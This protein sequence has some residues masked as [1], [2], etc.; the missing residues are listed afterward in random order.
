MDKTVDHPKAAAERKTSHFRLLIADW[1][2]PVPGGPA[3]RLSI[4]NR[5]L[6]F[7]VLVILAFGVVWLGFNALQNA[8]ALFMARTVQLFAALGS[9]P[10]RFWASGQEIYFEISHGKRFQ[11]WLDTRPMFSNFPL[12]LTLIAVTPGLL[13]RR[14]LAYVVS[15]AALL[16]LTHFCFLYIKVQV[17]LITANHIDAGSPAVWQT[18][19]DLFEVTGKTFFPIF[20][21]LLV[22]FPY[23]LGAVD[24]WKPREVSAQPRNAPC[25]CGSGLKYKKCCGR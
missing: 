13:W 22:A 24:T 3:S 18:L 15:G 7:V 5:L 16:L 6:F 25:S 12:L 2:A 19:D 4:R 10:I 23:M 9:Y 20:I 8:L 1:F 21:W 17:V 14:R 11:A